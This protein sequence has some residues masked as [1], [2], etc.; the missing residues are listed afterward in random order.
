M[1]RRYKHKKVKRRNVKKIENGLQLWFSK[2]VFFGVVCN[3]C[4]NI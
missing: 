3:V 1:R 4:Y 2:L